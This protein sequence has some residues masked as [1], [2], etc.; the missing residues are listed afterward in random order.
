MFCRT[1]MPWLLFLVLGFVTT[2]LYSQPVSEPTSSPRYQKY[3]ADFFDAVDT[4]KDGV[5]DAQ[6]KQQNYRPILENADQ[7]GDQLITG[8]EVLKQLDLTLANNIAASANLNSGAT[9]VNTPPVKMKM[10][11]LKLP[12]SLVR[13]KKIGTR[14]I[15]QTLSSSQRDGSKKI[16]LLDQFEFVLRN[17]VPVSLS[18][19]GVK[20]QTV[21][22]NNRDQQF[23]EQKEYPYQSKL[24][25]IPKLGE[26]NIELKMDFRANYGIEKEETSKGEIGDMPF[27]EPIDLSFDTRI[28]F[29]SQGTETINLFSSGNHFL[30]VVQVGI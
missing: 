17:N 19:G 5:I 24:R 15:F 10:V 28:A 7:D 22:W 16:L 20:L 14:E 12:E 6:E 21:K 1:A 27:I 2:D 13:S 23:Y 25:V 11:V 26:R 4:N 9:S 29:D 8:E 3:L 18:A 30:I